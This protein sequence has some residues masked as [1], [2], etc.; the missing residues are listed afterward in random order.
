MGPE[1]SLGTVV[2]GVDALA[3]ESVLQP[4]AVILLSVFKL[5]DAPPFSLSARRKLPLHIGVLLVFPLSL[6]SLKPKH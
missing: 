4:L 2:Q 5:E 1:D 3:V 6:M